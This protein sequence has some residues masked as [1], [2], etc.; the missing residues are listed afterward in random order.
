VSAEFG[1]MRFDRGWIGACCC[2]AMLLWAT[3]WAE[4]PETVWL[5]VDGQSRELRVMRGGDTLA[6]YEGIS[7][8]RAGIG[9]KQRRGD[10][11][12]PVGRYEITYVKPDSRFRR[13]FGINYPNHVDA[14]RAL[15][16]GRIGQ[17]T[18]DRIQAAL[19]QSRLPPQH[20]PLGG[21]VGIH[22]LGSG[23]LE[24]HQKYNWTRGCVALTNE[25]I[26]D[27]AA[28]IRKGTAVVIR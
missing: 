21:Y 16:D 1:P 24:I 4:R 2:I 5:L 8:G 14:R 11:V 10:D 15:E 22:G 13:F 17:P 26:D 3:A 27:L 9:G 12:T 6:V 19:E 28:W 7:V 20:T 25:Q 18:Y 23:S